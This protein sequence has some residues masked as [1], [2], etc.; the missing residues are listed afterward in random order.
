MGIY[1]VD[2]VLVDAGQKKTDVVLGVREVTFTENSLK[3][4]DLAT[5]RQLVDAAPCVIF[6]NVTQQVGERVKARLEKAGA[7]VE[8]K[9]A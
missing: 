7:T 9:P 5:T 8:L 4:M 3:S 6:S 1:F 2:V